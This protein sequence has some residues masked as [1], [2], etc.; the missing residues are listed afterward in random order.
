ME[1]LSDA[2]YLPI[3]DIPF[4]QYLVT[5]QWMNVKGDITKKLLWPFYALL[6]LF[7]IYTLFFLD[8]TDSK[9]ESTG[10]F[11]LVKQTI[12]LSLVGIILYFLYIEF[13]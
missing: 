2:K 1:K 7:S 3:M 11:L 12:N 10:L 9:E 6:A 4:I 13:Q 5:Y 8:Y